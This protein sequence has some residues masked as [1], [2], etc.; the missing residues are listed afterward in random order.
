MFV[1]SVSLI[2]SNDI[3]KDYFYFAILFVWK[4][5]YLELLFRY[6]IFYLLSYFLISK[7]EEEEEEEEEEIKKI[8]WICASNF[9]FALF[10][11]LKVLLHFVKG[12]IVLLSLNK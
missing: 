9:Y 1:F 5:F 12:L 11:Y 7:E 2:D 10:V 4:Y 8:Y 6:T 3:R